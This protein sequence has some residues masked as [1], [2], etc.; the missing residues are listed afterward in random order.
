MKPGLIDYHSATAREMHEAQKQSAT[1]LFSNKTAN[2]SHVVG[3]CLK[4]NISFNV[5]VDMPIECSCS[6]NFIDS[7]VRKVIGLYSHDSNIWLVW[8]VVACSITLLQG[9]KCRSY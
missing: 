2:K 9:Q 1:G 4:V 6:A 3:P 8:I 5:M 7:G